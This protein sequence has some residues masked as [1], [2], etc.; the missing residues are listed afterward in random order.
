MSLLG[1][2]FRRHARIPVIA[3]F[4]ADLAPVRRR[5]SQSRPVLLRAP[6][7]ARNGAV[8]RKAL[9]IPC[10]RCVTCGSFQDDLTPPVKAGQGAADAPSKSLCPQ[11]ASFRTI[12]SSP[13]R[14][15]TCGRGLTGAC[16]SHRAESA[17]SAETKTDAGPEAD[18]IGA[19]AVKDIETP[20]VYLSRSRGIRTEGG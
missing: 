4:P 7:N 13:T 11:T 8:F 10:S 20:G 12:R 5:V 15:L 2:N 17:A 1:G 19:S 18:I 14:H 9:T 3:A 16:S 6:S